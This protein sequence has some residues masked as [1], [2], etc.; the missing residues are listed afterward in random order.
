MRRAHALAIPA[1]LLTASLAAAQTGPPRLSPKAVVSQVVGLTEI[2]IEY[3]RPAVK[4]REVWGKLVPLDRVW[5]TGANEA[6]TFSVSS[7]VKVEGKP[8]AAGTY[9]LFTIPRQDRWT[10]IFNKTADQWGAFDYD[11][12]QDALRVDVK[13]V[14]SGMQERMEFLIDE[15]DDDSADVILRWENTAVVFTVSV[16]TP[17]LALARAEQELGG[18]PKVGP[19]VSWSRWLLD[20]DVAPERALAWIKQAVAQPDGA[21]RYWANATLARLEAKAGNKAGARAAAEKAL[22][23][24]ATDKAEGVAA[25]AEKLRAALDTW[26]G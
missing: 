9:A 16:D 22:D 12:K 11:E 17:K 6:T 4:A 24:A 19:L 7:D 20:N 18:S 2:K 14:Q 15:F 8:L 1:L 23:V 10:L 25:D 26:K 5:R 3:S 21:S 13:P